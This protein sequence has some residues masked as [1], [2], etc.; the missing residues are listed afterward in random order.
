MGLFQTRALPLLGDRSP[1]RFAQVGRS[2]S[3]CGQETGDKTPALASPAAACRQR[4]GKET[5]FTGIE[6]VQA[7]TRIAARLGPQSPGRASSRLPPRVGL[8]G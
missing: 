8:T 2:A 6:P 5:A 7:V 4:Q 1:G 3:P